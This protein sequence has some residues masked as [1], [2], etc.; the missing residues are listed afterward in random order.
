MERQDKSPPRESSTR[1]PLA[2]SLAPA[3]DRQQVVYN[4]PAG[5]AAGAQRAGS[6]S[7]R[8]GPRGSV[9][10][11]VSSK[12]SSEMPDAALEVRTKK[13]VAKKEEA[14]E[15]LFHSL[16]KKS[17]KKKDED[18]PGLLDAFSDPAV[19]NK[20][21]S[22]DVLSALSALKSMSKTMKPEPSAPS[23]QRLPEQKAKRPV[24]GNSQ[25][26]RRSRSDSSSPPPKA[27]AAPLDDEEE[28]LL[29][30]VQQLEAEKQRLEWMAE[31]KLPEPPKGL[32]AICMHGC[33]E[34]ESP[35]T[36][37]CRQC[38]DYL[39]KFCMSEHV[40]DKY[41]R[42]HDIGTWEELRLSRLKR[43]GWC[44][45]GVNMMGLSEDE[46]TLKNLCRTFTLKEVHK[47]IGGE[48]VKVKSKSEDPDLPADEAS[49]VG[50]SCAASIGRASSCESST[51]KRS[52][53]S[54]R[55]ASSRTASP[56]LVPQGSDF[57]NPPKR[58]ISPLFRDKN[59]SVSPVRDR[60][61]Q[62]GSASSCKLA[63]S[64][65]WKVSSETN[66]APNAARAPFL[67]GSEDE[68]GAQGNGDEE[69][70]EDQNFFDRLPEVG[71]SRRHR[72]IIGG[73]SFRDPPTRPGD[74]MADQDDIFR[75]VR[76]GTRSFIDSDK[77]SKSLASLDTRF[78]RV[79]S[80]SP[81]DRA[82]S[83][84]S[85]RL[86]S[87]NSMSPTRDAGDRDTGSV[88]R[89]LSS[90]GGS[91]KKPMSDLPTLPLQSFDG[92][93]N[94][95]TTRSAF[96]ASAQWASL[97]RA[98]SH[99]FINEHM[100]THGVKTFVDF[101]SNIAVSGKKMFMELGERHLLVSEANDITRPSYKIHLLEISAVARPERITG[102][103]PLIL[104][105]TM[106]EDPKDRQLWRTTFEG[107]RAFFCFKD[108][109]EV[110][111]W[112]ERIRQA[113]QRVAELPS[114]ERFDDELETKREPEVPSVCLHACL[115]VG[116]SP[117]LALGLL[118][119]EQCCDVFCTRSQRLILN[120]CLVQ[121]EDDLVRLHHLKVDGPLAKFNGSVANVTEL[122][123]CAH[124]AGRRCM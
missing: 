117:R 39:C 79:R 83:I 94:T 18:R 20:N 107:A 31:L 6:A 7:P 42:S 109:S 111:L 34:P 104:M 55:G 16:E 53:V 56:P 68:A 99:L 50:P 108:M 1:R 19:A 96:S 121:Q 41:T 22:P 86:R 100:E 37:V 77:Y 67:T 36:H 70:E 64:V 120:V 9:G 73:M 10:V 115:P 91:E 106:E 2:S 116:C 62:S 89:F 105:H 43:D 75:P 97:R 30:E 25:S 52:S 74:A 92:N 114:S 57:V 33:R 28:M 21:L 45:R 24:A 87:A 17:K 13:K 35:V 80:S 98:S 118:A 93:D 11:I 63:S 4:R 29:A 122:D 69:K 12:L 38:S 61:S 101:R 14:E 48:L 32:K 84:A 82:G 26:V 5:N 113:I 3:R 59:R 103:P 54:G 76:K 8:R 46:E 65:E 23:Q 102:L 124:S 27:R 110:R 123:R 40:V 88:G 47:V 90:L 72:G 81:L 44:A 15:E 60:H 71:A 49:V 119:A 78:S 85:V 95:E 66:L 51:S 112:S 58:P